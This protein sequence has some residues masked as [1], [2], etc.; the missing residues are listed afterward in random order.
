MTSPTPSPADTPVATLPDL[1]QDCGGQAAV[2]SELGI[3]RASVWEWVK[4]GRLPW[5]ELDGRTDY[6]S[7][8]AGMQREGRLT[9]D[10][11]RRLGLTL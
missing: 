2:A 1:I 9:P 7:V 8:L 6:S 4:R 11:I 5:S 10:Q 3:K